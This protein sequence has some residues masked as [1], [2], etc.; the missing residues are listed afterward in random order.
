MVFPVV[1]LAGRNRA[2]ALFHL[3]LSVSWLIACGSRRHDMMAGGT[4]SLGRCAGAFWLLWIL[5]E[6]ARREIKTT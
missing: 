3:G 2:R 1:R 5:V 6:L 4:F